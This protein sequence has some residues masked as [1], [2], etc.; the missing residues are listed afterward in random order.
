MKA[1]NLSRSLQN[2]KKVH[3]LAFAPT[4]HFDKLLSTTRIDEMP[5]HNE[6]RAFVLSFEF[7]SCRVSAVY[8]IAA[9]CNTNAKPD[10]AEQS[11]LQS[12]KINEAGRLSRCCFSVGRTSFIEPRQ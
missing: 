10:L 8:I 2:K 12:N 9:A 5:N 3:T 4:V 11:Q 1:A 6:W 7:S